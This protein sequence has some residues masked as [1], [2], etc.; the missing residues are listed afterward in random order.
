MKENQRE[1]GKKLRSG[2]TTGTC[3]AGAAKACSQMLLTGEILSTIA[4]ATPQGTIFNLPLTEVSLSADQASCAIRK[5]SGDDPDVSDGMLIHATV[6]KAPHG[7]ITL[8]GGIGIGR[9]TKPGLACGIGEAAIN[10]VPKKMIISEVEEVRE[11]FS[12]SQGLD[13]VIWAPLGEEIARKTFNPRLG[14][15]GG[16]SI[17]GT[18]GI[19]EPR[20]QKAL[21]DTIYLEMK[22]QRAL[23]QEN[24]LMCPGNYGQIFM[25]EALGINIEQAVK[26]SNFIGEALDFALEL[27]FSSLLLIGHAGKLIKLAAG[28]MN[29]HSKSADAR[30][31]ILAVHAALSGATTEMISRIMDSNTTEEAVAILIQAGIKEQVFNRIMNKVD[32]YVQNRLRHQLKTA[33]MLFSNEYGILG[34][35]ENADELIELHRKIEGR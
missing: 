25:K 8:D 19:V 34:K 33:V 16:I 32:F 1:Q 3:A 14:I 13:I 24:L 12:S 23:G 11:A 15:I 27:E 30:M 20:S 2:Y 29:T 21:L 31:E 6:T 5:D 28:I 26:C 4:V 22:Q 10:P 9:V 7:R 18:T 17:L 35:T